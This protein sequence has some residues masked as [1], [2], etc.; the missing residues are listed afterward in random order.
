MSRISVLPDSLWFLLSVVTA[1]HMEWYI[2][3]ATCFKGE[4]L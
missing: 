4:S 3:V 1:K 2:P